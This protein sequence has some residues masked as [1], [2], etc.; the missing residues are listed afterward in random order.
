[1]STFAF[2]NQEMRN[3]CH[4]EIILFKSYFETSVSSTS[5][6]FLYRRRYLFEF[7]IIVLK[8]FHQIVVSLL[9]GF[10]LFC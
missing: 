7:Y 3:L 2:C 9:Y 6:F 8:N 1:M 10:P 5:S 4:R